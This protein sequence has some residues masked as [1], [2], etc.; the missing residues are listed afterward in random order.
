MGL[1]PGNSHQSNHGR[2]DG[3][4]TEQ[5]ITILSKL[6]NT[7][8]LKPLIL[9]KFSYLLTPPHN[10][11]KKFMHAYVFRDMPYFTTFRKKG[12]LL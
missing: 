10:V 2:D 12:R 1:Y 5:V 11:Q 8:K 7:L 3:C 9:S 6:M 4:V